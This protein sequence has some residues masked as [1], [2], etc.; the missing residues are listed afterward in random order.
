MKIWILDDKH[1]PTGYAAG[2][3]ETKY[4]ERRKWYLADTT[5]DIFGGQ[6]THTLH[7]SRMLEAGDW[8]LADR[9]TGG[10]HRA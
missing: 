3:V 5:A 4:P 1:F 2:L 9:G 8:L 10:L 7:I 6:H